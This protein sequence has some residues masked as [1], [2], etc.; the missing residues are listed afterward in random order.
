MLVAIGRE[1]RIS[2]REAEKLAHAVMLASL[3]RLEGLE[4]PAVWLVA[5][6]RYASSGYATVRGGPRGPERA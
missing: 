3:R 5:A 4:D 6:M 1:F 2:R